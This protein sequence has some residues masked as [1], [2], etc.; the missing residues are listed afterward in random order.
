MLMLGSILKR[1][2]FIE[3]I[4]RIIR[5]IVNI[6][7]IPESVS[8]THG[9]FQDT[10]AFVFPEG[11]ILLALIL[12]AR[13]KDSTTIGKFQS[14]FVWPKQHGQHSG[15]RTAVRLKPIATTAN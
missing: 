6:W 14:S 11:S 2:I 1:K 15:V 9:G 7:R 5:Q 13:W 4:I 8:K 10:I 3:G 12:F